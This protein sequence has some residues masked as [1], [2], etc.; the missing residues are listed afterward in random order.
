MNGS[1]QESTEQPRRA[2]RC[3]FGLMALHAIWLAWSATWQS[4]TLN[5][6]GHLVSGIAHWKLGRFE[7]YAVNPPLVRMVAAIPVLATEY[8]VDWSGLRG[9]PGER[10]EFLLGSDFIKVNGSESQRLFELARWACIPFS[11]LGAWMCFV[12]GRALYGAAAGVLACA[13][14]CVEPNIIAHGQLITPDV[15][16]T[17]LGLVAMWTFWQWLKRPEWVT[18]IVAGVGLGAAVLAKF[19]WLMLFGIWP[20]IWLWRRLRSPASL[21]K[22]DFLPGL[23][24]IGALVVT[25]V[26]VINLAYAF[27]GSFSRLDSF[28]F[29]SEALSGQSEPGR[30]ANRFAGSWMGSIPLPVP[31]QMLL[32]LDLQKKD[33]EHFA[34]QSY[35]RG[36]WRQGGWWYYYLYAAAVKLPIGLWLLGLTAIVVRWRRGGPFEQRVGEA[37]LLIPAVALFVV[38]SSEIEF[39]HHFRYVLPCLGPVFVLAS[40]MVVGAGKWLRCWIIANTA[41][42]AIASALAA[43]HSLSYFNELAGG[44][45]NGG[46]HLLHSNIDWGQDLV[47]LKEWMLF[48]SDASPVYLAYYGYFDPKDYGVTA[49]ESPQGPFW[50]TRP[51]DWSFRPG[52]YAVSVNYL[53]GTAWRLQNRHAYEPLLKQAPVAWCGGSIAIYRVDESLARRLTEAVLRMRD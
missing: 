11:L 53:H 4:P 16:A 35:L 22:S 2:L 23:L 18:A 52:Y 19:S 14:W 34:H 38:V 26:Y 7:P 29:T 49:E 13:L 43:P 42:I 40:G 44:M 37:V 1:G 6:P 36:E 45:R 5:E 41:W 33:F 27:E 46:T 3:V 8:Q 25:A 28:Q 12:W 39:N 51:S 20:A 24:Q 50:G 30:T 9:R 10:A 17:S 48:N 32:G 47:A 21:E 31:R 15:A